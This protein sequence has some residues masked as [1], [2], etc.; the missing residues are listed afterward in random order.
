MQTGGQAFGPLVDVL[1]SYL[2]SAGPIDRSLVAD[3][4]AGAPLGP[5][6]A[7]LLPELGAAAPDVDGVAPD[8]ALVQAL[9][10][11]ARRHPTCLFLDDLHWADDATLELLPALARRLGDVPLLVVGAFRS[12]ELPRGH[13]VR[14][15]RS[16]LRRS[17]QLHQLLLEPL[18]PAAT[19]ALVEATIGPPAP[20]LA[21]A[22]FDRTD[23]IPFFVKELATALAAG[24]RLQPGP[25]GLELAGGDEVPLPESV[26]DAVLLRA[27]GLSDTAR[28]AVLAASV[29]GQSFD[30][31]LVA[32]VAGLPE[33]PDELARLG[34]VSEGADDRMAF[35]HALV[36]DA[37]YG[38]ITWSARI[39]LHRAVA[40]RLEAGGAPAVTVAEHWIAGRRPDR[41]RACFLVAADSFRAVHAYRD[42]ARA[43]RRALD[44]WPEN[45]EEAERLDVL[46]RL[47]DCAELAGNLAEAVPVRREAAEGLRRAGDGLGAA[48]AHRRLAAALELQGRWPEALASREQA[49]SAF[50]AADHPAEAALERLTAAAHLRSAGSFRAAL[51]LLELAGPEARSAGRLDVEARILGLDGNV[52][53]RMGE[54]P[55]AVEIVRRGLALALEHGF[56]GPAAEIYQR[57]A[58]SLEHSGDY[59]GAQQT[60]D[61]AFTF[62]STNGLEPTAQLCLAC[63]T[64]VLRQSGDWDR[65]AA[66]CRQ[67]IGST[68]ATVHARAVAT[69]MLGTILALRGQTRRSRPLLLEAVTLARRIEL[70]AME[71]LGLWGLALADEHDGDTQAAA[72]HCR[73]VLDRWRSTEDRHYVVSA[74]RW[75]TTFF[76]ESGDEEGVRTLCRHPG[77]DRRPLRGRRDDVRVVARPRRDRAAG[78]QRG[79]GERAFRPRPDPLARDRRPVR[80][81]RVR[82]PGRG[83]ARPGRPD[84]GGDRPPRRRAPHGAAARGGQAGPSDH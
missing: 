59:P 48:R 58:D 83:R 76:A 25:S 33:W 24:G 14:R 79:A 34:V 1:R 54:G 32:A 27:S 17:G 6:L 47:A 82:A 12:D 74:L 4:I 11:L 8:E 78:R 68:D 56:A 64:A 63:L 30:P 70:A 36:R 31:E 15:L 39:A 77:R 71:M 45:A 16:E 26:R 55:A 40:E 69:G 44:L 20:A 5:R 3:H 43:V 13:A 53:A 61:E 35:R 81:G 2:R 62:C 72:G 38:E 49:A 41:A 51:S 52:R 50:A 67:I 66:L 22:V 73:A 42:A 10:T 46:E 23:G 80:P 57:L 37:F 28:Q 19:A 65:A 7:P 9:T 60:Y 84:A 18:G 21:R 75:A 29:A